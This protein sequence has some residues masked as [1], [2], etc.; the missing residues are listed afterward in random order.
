[1][2]QVQFTDSKRHILLSYLTARSVRAHSLVRFGPVSGKTEKNRKR[3]QQK[4][5]PGHSTGGQPG[6]R[7][8]RL[9]AAA[10][11][12]EQNR[13]RQTG[14]TRPGDAGT[15]T[16]GGHLPAEDQ[17]LPENRKKTR[18]SGGERTH[19]AFRTS[20][21][22]KLRNIRARNDAQY[23]AVRVSR[24][25]LSSGSKRPAAYRQ[26]CSATIQEGSR[27]CNPT[28]LLQH[29]YGILQGTLVTGVL[30]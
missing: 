21:G 4:S 29:L 28:S 12:A 18:W 8:L 5:R 20:A 25:E 13:T 10:E 7:H 22:A 6:I 2:K 23:A 9:S 15:G 14:G 19:P 1:M 17:K 30:F 26:K 16:R 3:D 27:A 11:N 24:Q